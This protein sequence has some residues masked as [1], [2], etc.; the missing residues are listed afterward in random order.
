MRRKLAIIFISTTAVITLLFFTGIIKVSS[1]EQIR[2]LIPTH[3]TEEQSKAVGAQ[4]IQIL[5][6]RDALE[7]LK[8]EFPDFPESKIQGIMFYHQEFKPVGKEPWSCILINVDDR[9]TEYESGMIKMILKKH[10]ERIIAKLSESITSQRSQP[11][12]ARINSEK[13]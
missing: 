4:A 3:L 2:V 8:Q 13:S 10:A 5:G 11:H 6:S 1:N 7:A 9:F 12:A